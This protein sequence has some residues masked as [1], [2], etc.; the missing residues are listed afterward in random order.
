MRSRVD[1]RIINT[2]EWQRDK[3]RPW[4]RWTV[5]HLES[6]LLCGITNFKS[7]DQA[8]TK[9]G[10]KPVEWWVFSLTQ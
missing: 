10:K 1:A 5:N 6:I 7:R 4:N 3:G 2:D 9:L 8:V